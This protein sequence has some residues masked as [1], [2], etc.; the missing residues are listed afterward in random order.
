MS[1]PQLGR[2]VG[3]DGGQTRRRIISATIACV[4]D[5]G[6]AR[7]TI[8]QIASTAGVTSA[9]LYNY[10]PNKADLVAAAIAARAEIALPRLRRAAERPGT[11]VERIEAVLDESGDLMREHPDLATFEW[12]IRAQNAVTVYP[13]EDGGEGLRALRDIIAGIVDD[14]T[15]GGRPAVEVVYA[16]VYGLTELAATGSAETY[17]AA[18]AAAKRLIRGTLFIAH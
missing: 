12:A 7:T 16:L 4:A 11:V 13:G 8:R 1:T 17:H 5:V 3:A 15:G 18:L 9:N 2:P 14:G 6:Y 10:F